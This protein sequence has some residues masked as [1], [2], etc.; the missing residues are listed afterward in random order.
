MKAITAIGSDVINKKLKETKS[1]RV[2][3]KDI[4]Y[5]EGIFE[6]LDVIKDINVILISDNLPGS[7]TFE[8]LIKKIKEKYEKIEIIVFLDIYNEYKINFLNSFGIF[9]IYDLKNPKLFYMTLGQSSVEEIQDFK[10]SLYEKIKNNKTEI[11]ND[12]ER[13]IEKIGEEENNNLYGN[14]KF[15]KSKI[16]AIEGNPGAGKS[17]MACLFSKM[18]SEKNK[19]VLLVCTNTRENIPNTI[20]GLKKENGINKYKKFDIY[21]YTSVKKRYDNKLLINEEKQNIIELF[22]CFIQNYDYI[23]I[24]IDKVNDINNDFIKISYEY[25]NLII[26]ICEPNL[27]GVTKTKG[28]IESNDKEVIKKIKI[29]LNKVNKYQIK[30]YIL[31][32]IFNPIQIIGKVNYNEKIDLLINKNFNKKIDIEGIGEIIDK[33]II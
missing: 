22:I 1:Y 30:E 31:K 8:E 3:G 17:I 4:I 26:Y 25:S 32:N 14:Y 21:T 18:I 29:L 19:K 2:V 12:E 13:R 16:I 33:I 20:L 9:K 5:Q 15:R 6:I 24:D 27:I 10:D 28:F 23:V 7:F 11:H